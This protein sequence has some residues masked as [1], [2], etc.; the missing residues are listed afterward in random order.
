MHNIKLVHTIHEINLNL[1]NYRIFIANV[2]LIL[3]HN[4]ENL[5]DSL[6]DLIDRC[7]NLEYLEFD[8]VLRNVDFL[9]R[10]CIWDTMHVDRGNIRM[11]NSSI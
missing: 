5:D 10:V 8:G 3:K 9:S 4:R 1:I 2:T 11:I 7:K 6:F